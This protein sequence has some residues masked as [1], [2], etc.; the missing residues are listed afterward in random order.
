V[1]EEE[2][3]DATPEN[4]SRL[5]LL[6]AYDKTSLD[7]Q[8]TRLKEYLSSRLY[9]RDGSF[10]SD[11]AFTLG[12][13]RSLLPWKATYVADSPANLFQRLEK[14]DLPPLRSTKVPQIGFV[15]T[16]QGAQWHG[17]GR[18]LLTSNPVF[19][20][21][22]DAT[23]KSI[24]KFGA[25]YNLRD[26]ILKDAKSSRLG[27]ASISQ[28]A[29]TAIQIALVLMLRSWGVR[30]TTVT[31]HSSG[32]IA[33][34][35][36][37]DALSLES[38]MAI[39]YHRGEAAARLHQE[40]PEIKGGM[41]ALGTSE[42]AA[43]SMIN[44]LG[45][46]GSVVVA[47]VNSP[48]SVTISGDV[49]AID[50]LQSEAG[51]ISLFSRKLHVDVAYHSHHLKWISDSYLSALKGIRPA[52]S[53]SVQFV[54]S[55]T[56]VPINSLVL[57]PKYW[58]SNLV[59]QVKF[60]PAVEEIHARS[61]VDVLIEIGPH[62]ALA[63]PVREILDMELSTPRRIE[64][65]PSLKRNSNALQSALQLASE[66]LIRGCA[67]DLSAVNQGTEKSRRS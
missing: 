37:A 51:E 57:S 12:Q 4:P 26:E 62:S 61:K 60:L 53:P 64:Y 67:I 39:A 3:I 24:L 40:H 43:T 59:S 18:D 5:F 6:A 66:L 38:C 28:P 45:L 21:A 48:S 56:G 63:G 55:L 33:A 44:D 8:A 22:I 47:C 41:L 10:L 14:P 32:E 36:A 15:F 46:D 17:M 13:R 27:K 19:A 54:S 30:P 9:D 42:G 20:S 7:H 49:D 11:L 31:G 23:T 52:Q 2:V 25:S 50:R 34:A 35:F 58:V 1:L 65:L 29:C 16:G